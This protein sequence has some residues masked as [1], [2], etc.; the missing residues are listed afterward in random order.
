MLQEFKNCIKEIL[1]LDPSNNGLPNSIVLAKKHLITPDVLQ[2]FKKLESLYVLEFARMKLHQLERYIRKCISHLRHIEI[3]MKDESGSQDEGFLILSV[4]QPQQQVIRLEIMFREPITQS[5]MLCMMHNYPSLQELCF[6]VNGPLDDLSD[7]VDVAITYQFLEYL[8]KTP[9]VD[10][11]EIHISIDSIP[12]LIHFV[13][14][15][16]QVKTVRFSALD[17][18]GK[19]QAL[20]SLHH[21]LKNPKTTNNKSEQIKT[22]FCQ[23]EVILISHEPHMLFSHVLNVFKAGD[24]EKLIIGPQY[25]Q[26]GSLPLQITRGM[27]NAILDD[28]QMLNGLVFTLVE[29]PEDAPAVPATGRK[30]CLETLALQECVIN[31]SYLAEFSL[32]LEHVD[33]LKYLDSKVDQ[34]YLNSENA[35]ISIHMP[36]TTFTNIDFAFPAIGSYLIK[37]TTADACFRIKTSR[38]QGLAPLSSEEYHQLEIANDTYQVDMVCHAVNTITTNHGSF[39]V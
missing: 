27:I 33:E 12:Q 34:Y 29:F 17:P 23:F 9:Y 35:K 26:D 20:I 11:D 22:H 39:N 5:D 24:I 36:H 30:K 16:I 19:D 1:I 2:I 8:F 15:S 7:S 28:Y 14:R 6:A 25:I 32:Q 18:K 13:A 10:F 37:V 38:K 21:N 3:E 31:P 4:A